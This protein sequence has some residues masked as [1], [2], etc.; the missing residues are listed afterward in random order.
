MVSCRCFYLAKVYALLK[1]LDKAALVN[2]HASLYLRQTRTALALEQPYQTMAQEFMPLV[3]ADLDK[4]ERGISGQRSD[5]I[6]AWYR[7]QTAPE[8]KEGLDLSDLTLQD[9]PVPVKKQTVFDISYNYVAE[10]QLAEIADRAA[11]VAPK[12]I[13]EDVE[14]AAPEPEPEVATPAAKVETPKKRGIWGLW[15]S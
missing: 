15:R 10:F 12:Q 4:F 9:G 1:A 13:A 2:D 3:L 6:Q 5:I 14:M 8:T 7:A 11:G